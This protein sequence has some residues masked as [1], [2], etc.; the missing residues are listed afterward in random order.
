MKPTI[1]RIGTS[2][3]TAIRDESDKVIGCQ[4]NGYQDRCESCNVQCPVRL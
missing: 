3:L 4:W 2:D 1:F